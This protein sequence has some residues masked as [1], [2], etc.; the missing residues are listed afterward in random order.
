MN[1]LTNG[2][3]YYFAVRAIGD[4]PPVVGTLEGTDSEAVTARPS[5]PV[6][7]V[8]SAPSAQDSPGD[9]GG[10]GAS[11]RSRRF[12]TT[13]FTGHGGIDTTPANGDDTQDNQNRIQEPTQNMPR[14][15]K[16]KAHNGCGTGHEEQDGA[17]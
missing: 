16:D 1:G 8:T 6:A 5:A 17:F 10:G 9:D 4:F 11:S 13:Q 14:K 12:L 7:A 3:L 2:T 15:T